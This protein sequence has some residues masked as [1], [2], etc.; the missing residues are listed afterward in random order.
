MHMR[1]R[2]LLLILFAA[3]LLFA[4][5]CGSPSEDKEDCPSFADFQLYPEIGGADNVYELYVR[6]KSTDGSRK[7]DR[8]YAQLFFSSGESAGVTFDLVRTEADHLRFLRTFR[9]D[10]VCEAGTCSLYF[11][12]IA[13]NTNGCTKSFETDI[14]QVVIDA[15]DDDVSD[16]DTT[17]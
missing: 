2:H 9:G 7:V 10:E 3:G 16:D 13:H 17:E 11:R 1:S 15:G 12:V 14:F 5:A 6:L 4:G 8:V